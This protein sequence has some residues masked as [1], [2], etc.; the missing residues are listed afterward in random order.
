MILL[1]FGLLTAI[2][3]RLALEHK[4]WLASW[5]AI[6]EYSDLKGA[7]AF[8]MSAST[9]LDTDCSVSPFGIRTAFEVLE[10]EQGLVHVT[11]LRQLDSAN[12]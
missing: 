12:H 2:S 4:E 5:N 10:W 7:L 9:F 8:V 11:D 3:F 1:S 6:S